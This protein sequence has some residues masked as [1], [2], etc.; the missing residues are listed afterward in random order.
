MNE[1]DNLLL[2]VE[3]PNSA[4]AVIGAKFGG[5]GTILNRIAKIQ[6]DNNSSSFFIYYKY[7]LEPLLRASS[8]SLYT[9][10]QVKNISIGANTQHIIN[11]A[12]VSKP[13]DI[14]NPPALTSLFH[15]LNDIYKQYTKQI[16]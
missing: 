10:T 3:L 2:R 1:P 5:C 9:L 4:N 8:A 16:K 15:F 11:R 14:P 12:N 13:G 7:Q 6:K